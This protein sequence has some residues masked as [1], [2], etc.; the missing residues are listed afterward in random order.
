MIIPI[1]IIK[2]VRHSKAKYDCKLSRPDDVAD[3]IFPLVRNIDR[4]V[5]I[6]I[7]LDSS[8]TPNVINTVSIGTLNSTYVS[9]REV[10][11]SL[12]LSNCA[13]FVCAHNHVSGSLIPSECDKEVTAK[14]RDAGNLLDIK[15]IDHLIIGHGKTFFSFYKSNL[16]TKGVAYTE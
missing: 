10:F 14:L 2:Q 8:N 13:S 5:F 11:K 16:I 3:L 4:E 7:G 9:L 12:I 6:V 1:V 15:L